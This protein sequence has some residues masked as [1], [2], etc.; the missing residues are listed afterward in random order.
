MKWLIY[1]NGFNTYEHILLLLLL[2][3]IM[4][5]VY[6]INNY[7]YEF[8]VNFFLIVRTYF[9]F[10]L[11]KKISEKQYSLFYITR[12]QRIFHSDNFIRLYLNMKI[13]I[14]QM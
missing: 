5:S 12:I 13:K 6:L 3:T 2:L 11:F 10:L 9:K 8:I 4:I 7:E 14:I 1:R